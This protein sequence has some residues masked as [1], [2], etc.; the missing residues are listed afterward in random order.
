M[1]VLSGGTDA[2][3][4]FPTPLPPSYTLFHIVRYRPGSPSS[5]RKRI[6]TSLDSSV[7]GVCNW[8]SGHWSGRAGMAFHLDFLMP[9]TSPDLHGDRW[10]LS[11]DQW[12]TYRSQGVNRT[13]NP[14]APFMPSCWLNWG[15]NIHPYENG[16]WEA[17][18][19]LAYNWQL[20]AEEVAETEAWLAMRYG[21]GECSPSACVRVCPCERA[22]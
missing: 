9:S 6:V 19:V 20:S 7:T 12:Q 3:I 21:L 14:P 2:S 22:C 1:S 8:L 17:A 16:Q 5:E 18:A 4:T 15:I 11:S 10:V 13:T